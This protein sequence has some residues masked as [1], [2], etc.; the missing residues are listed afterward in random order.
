MKKSTLALCAILSFGILFPLA[1][2]AA[3]TNVA[4]S[5]VSLTIDGSALLAIQT[6]SN[7]SMSLGG[8]SQ[9]GAAVQDVAADTTARLRISSLVSGSTTRT[10]TAILGTD[11][12]SSH[13]ELLVQLLT[14]NSNFSNPGNM[15]TLTTPG[16]V[17]SSASA[18]QLAS[19]IK[20]CWSGI[21]TDDGYPIAYTFRRKA[22]E[23]SFTTPGSIVVTYTLSASN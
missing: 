17:L 2:K 6:G 10:I 19:G 15:G 3:D 5:T 8:A 13:T 20:T 22:G 12:T 21:G 23:T 14:P 18:V 1:L 9:A 4:T 7:I 11:M 16:T